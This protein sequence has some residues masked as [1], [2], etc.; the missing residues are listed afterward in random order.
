[1]EVLVPQLATATGVKYSDFTGGFKNKKMQANHHEIHP[2]LPL[3]SRSGDYFIFLKKKKQKHKQKKKKK[4][5]QKPKNIPQTDKK[6]PKLPSSDITK[7]GLPPPVSW[8]HQGRPWGPVQYEGLPQWT[9]SSPGP[10][11]LL[12]GWEN[13][14]WENGGWEIKKNKKGGGGGVKVENCWNKKAQINSVDWQHTRVDNN[15]TK[16]RPVASHR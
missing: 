15:K 5:S 8:R 4:N 9:L 1:M 16:P 2:T 14:G 7:V 13:G 6:K 10:G 11:R 12:G 3:Q